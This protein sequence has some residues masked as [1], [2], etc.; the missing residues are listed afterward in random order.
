M[1]FIGGGGTEVGGR[2]LGRFF[3]PNILKNLGNA[4]KHQGCSGSGRVGGELGCI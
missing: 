3:S 2:Q 1:F 4:Q